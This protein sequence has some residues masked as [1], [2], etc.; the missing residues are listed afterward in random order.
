MKHR[1]ILIALIPLLAASALLGQTAASAPSSAPSGKPDPLAVESC[2]ADL[3]TDDWILQVSALRLL[4]IWKHSPAVPEI[5]AVLTGKAQAYVRGQALIALAEIEPAQAAKDAVALAADK[6]PELRAACVEAL[7]IIADPAGEAAIR[8][9]LKDPN[10]LVVQRAT[11]ALARLKGK[12]A[13]D[14]ISALLKGTDPDG[15]QAAAEACVYVKTPEARAAAAGLLANQDKDVRLAAVKALGKMKGSDNVSDLL[16]VMAADADA[17]VKSAALDALALFDRTELV[18]PLMAAFKAEKPDLYAPAIRVLTA[19]ADADIAAR[20][21]AAVAEQSARYQPVLAEVLGLLAKVDADAYLPTLQANLTNADAN[22]RLAAIRC[23]AAAKKADLFAAMK[24]LLTDKIVSVRTAAFAALKK[25]TKGAP[26]DGIAAYLADAFSAA[27]PD[28]SI[29]TA[30]IDLLKERVTAGEAAKAAKMLEKFFADPNDT[31]RQLA[32]AAL[33][34][35]ANAPAA[36]NIAQKQGYLLDWAV[37]GS[38]PGPLTRIY[39]PDMA[40]DLAEKLPRHNWQANLVDVGN[41]ASAG[42][43]KTNVL[44]IGGP[45]DA[46]GKTLVTY[47][48]QLPQAKQITLKLQVG[49]EDVPNPAGL[50]FDVLV[51]DKSVHSRKLPKPEGFAAVD[52]DLSELAGKTMALTFCVAGAGQAENA[53]IAQA[54]IQADGKQTVDLVAQA[55]TAGLRVELDD[56]KPEFITWQNAQAAGVSGL[57]S[58]DDVLPPPFDGRIAYAVADLDSPAE[59]NVQLQVYCRSACQVF[60]NG[61]KLGDVAAEGNQKLKATLT[62]DRN[63][64]LVKTFNEQSLWGVSV[65][66]IDEKGK[67][68]LGLGA[69]PQ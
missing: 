64:L 29:F 9:A 28:Y 49:M 13:W 40:I 21:A 37:L 10:A 51:D 34:Q 62:K 66:V 58:L 5:R 48:L 1:A 60:L 32:A 44:R 6:S 65:R 24:P 57:L 59:Q 68:L 67:A 69:K 56:A 7:A 11:V 27:D 26:A 36:R 53:A 12:A 52:V 43:S 46:R 42:T 35:V 3:K 47:C 14:S 54:V 16:R 31:Y 20:V 4:S 18:E 55:A 45:R 61:K 17:E 19:R 15:L 33:A 39:R 41:A 8:N 22:I 38:L 50:Q 63:R 30:A 2:L 25:S 23:V